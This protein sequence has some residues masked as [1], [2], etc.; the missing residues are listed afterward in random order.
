M[1]RGKIAFKNNEQIGNMYVQIELAGDGSVW[2]TKHE[3]VELFN[4][5]T[6]TVN[7]NLKVIFKENELFESEVVRTHRYKNKKGQDCSTEFY[8]L[9][10]IIALSFRMKGAVCRAFREWIRKQAKRPIVESHQNPIVILIGKNIFL[11]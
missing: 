1:E 6:S 5:F 4:V 7:A 11:A 10:V 9:D 3:I 2:L 8:N